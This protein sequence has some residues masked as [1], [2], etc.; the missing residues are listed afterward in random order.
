MI[1][2]HSPEN[3]SEWQVLA[4]EIIHYERKP[5]IYAGWLWCTNSRGDSAW[6]PEGW[7]MILDSEYC[8]FIRDYDASE[9]IIEIGQIL[10]GDTIESGWVL[11]S[12]KRKKNGWVPLECLEIINNV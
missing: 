7:V 12:D 9:L 2:T 10:E 8:R 1:K 6:A 11:V 3:Q 4:G 5:T